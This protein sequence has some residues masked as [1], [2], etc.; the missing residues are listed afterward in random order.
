MKTC[1]KCGEIKPVTEY[2]KDSSKRDGICSSCKAC[3]KKSLNKEAAAVWYAANRDKRKA[4]YAAWY[5]KNVEKRR[6]YGRDYY[7]ANKEKS[8]KSTAAWRAANSERHKSTYAAWSS[9]NLEKRRL[10]EQNRR[11]KKRDSG[12][13]L[14]IGLAER[15]FEMQRGKCA[16]CGEPLG[17]N[18]HLDHIMP[19]ALGGANTDNNIQL[20]RAKCNQAKYAKHPIDYM[21]SK[22]FL[23]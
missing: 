1:S 15:L 11:A 23:L 2:F 9:A 18:Y 13:K 6:A 16:C 22:G 10:I 21:Q 3:H 17:N 4:D 8:K 20:L 12:G 14:S 7:A 5:S 19:L